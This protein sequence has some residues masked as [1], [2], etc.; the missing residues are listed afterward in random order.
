MAVCRL[1][2]PERVTGGRSVAMRYDVLAQHILA[3]GGRLGH[4]RLVAVDGPSGAGKSYF[5]RHLA[6]AVNAC[7]VQLE[8]VHSDDLL[9]GWSEQL[10]FW[11]RLEKHVLDP[12][13][14]RRDGGFH[15]YDWHSSRWSET[16]TSVAAAPVVILEGVSTSR[17]EVHQDLNL[18]IFVTAPLEVRIRRTI[19]RDGTGIE[20]FMDRWRSAEAKFFEEDQTASR[21]DLI[22]SGDPTATPHDPENEFIVVASRIDGIR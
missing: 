5:S 10:T 11:P 17:S 20:P 9:D 16:W 8:V 15:P 22:V 2:Y 18:A 14:A 13:R 19:E 1:S 21:A 7:G 6:K 4:S 3:S 12:I